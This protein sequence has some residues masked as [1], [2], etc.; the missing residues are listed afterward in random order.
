MRI[1]LDTN[2]LIAGVIA[3]GLCEAMVDMC[4]GS[5][6][7]TAVLSEHILLEL[8]DRLQSKLDVPPEKIAATVQYLRRQAELVEPVSVPPDACRDPR[9]LP[10]LG[11]L[12][13]ARADCL[14]TGDAD[15]LSLKEY[16]GRPILS[17]RQCY[18][19][20]RSPA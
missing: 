3:R 18:E 9:D 20:M 7:H 19:Q 14:V 16:G 13:A 6:E 12:V 10:V 4:L 8:R 1:V 11:T 5:H 2:V 15:L 17:P